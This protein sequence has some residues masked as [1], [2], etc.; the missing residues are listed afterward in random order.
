M[1]AIRRARARGTR[2][3]AAAVIV[4]VALSLAKPGHPAEGAAG[5]ELPV[6]RSVTFQVASPYLISYEELAGLV[7]LHPGDRLTAEAVRESIRGLYAKSVFREVAAY[8]RREG[9]DADLRFYLRPAPAIVE[10]EVRG[11]KELSA[12]QIVAASRIRRGATMDDR[13]YAA[14]ADAVLAEMRKWGLTQATVS[15]S[16]LCNVENG[17]GKV[18]IDVSEGRPATVRSIDFPGATFFTAEKA[19]ELLG[20]KA[21]EPFDRRRWEEGIKTL[22]RAYKKAGFLTVHLSEPDL[23]CAGE[24]EGEEGVCP[25]AR[26][27][28]GPRYDV[29]WEGATHFSVRKL[30]EVSGIFGDEEATEGG[31][32]LDLRERLMAFY[33]SQDYFRAEVTVEQGPRD[34]GVR[35][36]RILID[37]GKRGYLKA[38][39]F[40]G[41][42]SIPAA[43]LRKQMTSEE[44]GAFSFL[45]GSGKLR[46]DE[47]NADLAALIGLY[48]KEGFARARIASVESDWDDKGGITRTIRIDEG[49]RYRVREIVF[50]GNDHFLDR[51]LLSLI[52]NRQGQS[53][54]YAGL[55]REQEAIAA[56]YRN[57][58][59]LDA[60][61]EAGLSFDEGKDTVVIRFDITEGPRYRRGNVIVRGTLLTDPV[62]VLREVTVAPGEP[63]GEDKLLKFQQA[64]FATGLYKTVRIRRVK[65]PREGIVDLV[66]EVDETL[67]FEVEFGGGYGTD[68]GIRG[69]VGARSLNLDGKGRRLSTQARASRIEQTLVG[70]LR[71]PWV[72]GSRWKWEGGLTASYS[73]S[74]SKSFSLRKSSVVTSINKTIF[75]RSSFSLQYEYS[76]NRPYDVAP[77]AVLAPE[78]KEASNIGA[79]RVLFVLDL[80]DDPFNPRRGSL[81][82]VSAEL[83]SSFFGSEVGYY[84]ISGQSSWYFP[85]FRRAT[86]VASGRGGYA[87]P[88]GDTGAVPIQKRFFL[89]GRTTVRGF[90]EQSIGPRAADG[91][92]IGGD[93]MVN[94]NLE[95]RVPLQRGFILAVFV[96][97]GSAWLGGHVAGQDFDLREAAG[98]GLRY[99][100]PVGPI[101]FDYGWKLDRRAG[102]SPG[103]WHF[104]IGSVF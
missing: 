92:V 37:E 65:R 66:V 24:E 61:V 47:W 10:I 4:V 74:E 82:S 84:E 52:G 60:R 56:H 91:T 71:E 76:R 86:F 93:Y 12:A 63:V 23:S 50:K 17:G 19:R 20:M 34:G 26:V 9:T 38:I 53:V 85:V 73:D 97:A 22:R 16:A 15:I 32:A 2:A 31:I 81:N 3:V 90:S 8:V 72:L 51:E 55:D 27:E 46:E 67:F 1:A 88:Y 11:Q 68:T 58:G 36:L 98:L 99:V 48:Q 89:G 18:R 64:V 104:T 54:D 94:G 83:A 33:M 40:E 7:T 75:E 70:D 42:A 101:S 25:S 100:T 87:S 39:R 41:N 21:G 5:G 69:F 14:A 30:E 43:K 59:Y 13:D 77:G 95:L 102:E 45:T 29:R 79:L 62:V 35:P 78:D 80:R 44:K 57:A 6:V 103:E 49:Q 96:D 28:E